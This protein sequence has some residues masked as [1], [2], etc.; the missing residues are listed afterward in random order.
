MYCQVRGCINNE[1]TNSDPGLL[2]FPFP[3][4]FDR[5][6]KWFDLCGTVGDIKSEKRT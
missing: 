5:K 6:V 3:E 2:F 1:S 4:E